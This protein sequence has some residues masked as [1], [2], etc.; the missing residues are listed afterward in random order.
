MGMHLGPSIPCV[1]REKR[2]AVRNG[3]H[4]VVVTASLALS[5]LAH[6]RSLFSIATI[7]FHFSFEFYFSLRTEA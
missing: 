1:C 7:L 2:Q 4:V 5:Y 3:W 6:V